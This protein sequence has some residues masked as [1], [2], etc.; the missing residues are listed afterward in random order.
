MSDFKLPG[1]NQKIEDAQSDLDRVER[2]TRLAEVQISRSWNAYKILAGLI[3]SA[4]AIIVAVGGTIF[5][6]DLKDFKRDMRDTVREELNNVTNRLEAE[7]VQESKKVDTRIDEE[8]K[9]ESIDQLVQK[10]VSQKIEAVTAKIISDDI[11]TE[12]DPKLSQITNSM[13]D[14]KADEIQLEKKLTQIKLEISDKQAELEAQQLRL[15]T[16]MRIQ[17]LSVN[18]KAGVLADYDQLKALADSKSSLRVT[19]TAY[20][21][22][23]E[24]FYSV[25]R[26]HD[27]QTGTADPV[28]LQPIDNSVED[29]VI[30]LDSPD[31]RRREASVNALG[32]SGKK[33]VVSELCAFLPRETNLLVIARTTL[34]VNNLAGTKFAPLEYKQTIAWWQLHQLESEYL[35]PYGD[36][37]KGY[38]L[39]E[40]RPVTNGQF[41]AV[42][43][44]MKSITAKEPSSFGA[45]CKLGEALFNLG[46]FEEA[47]K[48]LTKAENDNPNYRWGPLFHAAVYVQMHKIPQAVAS[49]NHALALSPWLETQA[50]NQAIFY[51]LLSNPDV[52]WPSRQQKH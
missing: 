3:F 6:S 2:L 14:F 17:D 31:S 38:Y 32:N 51:S 20:L 5:Y 19:A 41:Q 30:D 33:L 49:M 15:E 39:L 52:K 47:D 29:A 37:A 21:S 24:W 44:I 23:V 28:S 26:N 10:K 11:H 22:D 34:A 7:F 48:E 42:V 40:K 25:A 43:Q 46:E 36:Y 13:A 12:I 35:S 16:Q 45:R 8:F 50:T 18:A 4:T 9:T 1:S 27:S